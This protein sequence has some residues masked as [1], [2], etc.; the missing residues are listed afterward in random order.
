MRWMQVCE[1]CGITCRLRLSQRRF[2]QRFYS[3]F[4][5]S[6][7]VVC[8]TRPT[9]PTGPTERQ[10]RN[11]S[12]AYASAVPNPQLAAVSVC[13]RPLVV[14]F[15]RSTHDF[16]CAHAYRERVVCLA[17]PRAAPQHPPEFAARARVPTPPFPLSSFIIH[18]YYFDAL[19]LSRDRCYIISPEADT[20]LPWK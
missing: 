7:S 16:W 11:R 14:T 20:E 19:A 18:H 6:A 8:R 4:A 9:C 13:P 2:G 15:K 17:R 10:V 3:A 1:G 5:S 12:T